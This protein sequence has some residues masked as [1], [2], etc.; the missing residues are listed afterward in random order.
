[1]V[2]FIKASVSHEIPIFIF[3]DL[4]ELDKHT[5]QNI[6]NQLINCLHAF[7]FHD[8]YLQHDGYLLLATELVF[9]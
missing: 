8:S 6:V 4:V 2:V 9:Y 3:L 7:G 5:A 1:M